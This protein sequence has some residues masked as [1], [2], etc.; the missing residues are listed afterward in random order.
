M[1]EVSMKEEISDKVNNHANFSK[2]ADNLL[3]L[4]PNSRIFAT[5]G[6]LVDAYHGEEE[7]DYDPSIFGPS[8][9]RLE[10]KINNEFNGKLNE[11]EKCMHFTW[12][13]K[14]VDLH[15][16]APVLIR[17]LDNFEKFYNRYLFQL[18]SNYPFEPYISECLDSDK[19]TYSAGNV[20]AEYGCE[21]VYLRNQK[22]L[23]DL[24]NKRIQLPEAERLRY[25]ADPI[26]RTI[27]NG[28][29]G[30]E[31]ESETYNYIIENN[32][33]DYILW[34]DK[35][36]ERDLISLMEDKFLSTLLRVS[37]EDNYDGS[38]SADFSEFVRLCENASILKSL[39]QINLQ[40]NKRRYDSKEE[41]VLEIFE[42]K[43]EAENVFGGN[44]VFENFYDF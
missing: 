35:K 22:A 30:F 31:I 38:D 8:I 27:K 34:S 42:T 25:S 11:N 23:Q 44:Y 9:E 18:E 29:T 33:L 36:V 28:A 41:V 40:S 4:F 1:K 12:N 24:E 14:T 32:K 10:Q 26:F 16:L 43:K 15:I 20:F 3:E 19:I 17:P 37:R 13:K 39:F 5:S 2:L 7:H 6:F 21:N